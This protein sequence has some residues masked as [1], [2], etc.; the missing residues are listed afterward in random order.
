[1]WQLANSALLASKGQ[2]ENS[3]QWSDSATTELIKVY[4]LS[5]SMETLCLGQ[6][7]RILK[8][9]MGSAAGKG[10]V[11][12]WNR[13]NNHFVSILMCMSYKILFLPAALQQHFENKLN[14]YASTPML[15]NILKIKYFTVA[16]ICSH[17]PFSITK[18]EGYRNK[19]TNPLL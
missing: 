13:I 3:I 4:H 10:N 12:F 5:K 17:R 15:I 2:S 14:N 6:L 19:S 8:G 16:K 11:L 7:E 1:M 18:D 9:E